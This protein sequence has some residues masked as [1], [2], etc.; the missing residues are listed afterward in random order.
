MGSAKTL[1][2]LMIGAAILGTLVLIL[3]KN[4]RIPY[5][6]VSNRNFYSILAEK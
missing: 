1:F 3:K 6:A 4:Y 2:Y 5:N